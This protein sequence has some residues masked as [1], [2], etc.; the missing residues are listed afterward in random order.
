MMIGFLTDESALRLI[1]TGTRVGERTD[2]FRVETRR[3][4]IDTDEPRLDALIAESRRE[5]QACV[6]PAE[7]EEILLR[8]YDLVTGFSEDDR[9]AG[10]TVSGA[11][12]RQIAALAI[13]G[14]DLVDMVLRLELDR[15]DGHDDIEDL[16]KR[17]NPAAEAEIHALLGG[18]R[19][20][21]Y[22]RS[23]DD[24]FRDYARAA[25][26]H[27]LPVDAAIKAYDIRR[28]SETAA[29]E[30]KSSRELAP[31]QRRAALDA[32]RREAEQA[33][34]SAVGAAALGDFFRADNG[35]ARNAF[36]ARGGAR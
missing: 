15:P 3:I 13:R 17:V 32:M 8:G 10:V 9:L 25:R 33:M 27:Q 6:T 4:L 22:T 7:A 19:S 2:A 26:Q 35:W 16:L 18:E 14:L 12:L 23:K 28:A 29:R 1:E 34:Q 36:G 20:A 24:D 31:E 21:A 11:E 30:L 5:L